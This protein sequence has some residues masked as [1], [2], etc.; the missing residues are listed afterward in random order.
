MF[1]KIF[2]F[3]IFVV[4]FAGCDDLIEPAKENNRSLE[5]A[6]EEAAF[7]QG[8]LLNGYNRVPTNDWSFSDV[9]TDNAVTNDRNS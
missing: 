6:H 8:L 2:P 1:K 4:V 5:D 9:A 3:L 7:A